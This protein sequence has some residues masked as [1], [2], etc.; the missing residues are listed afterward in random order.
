MKTVLM[1]LIQVHLQCHLQSSRCPCQT[2]L[3]IFESGADFK[4]PR[5]RRDAELDKVNNITNST[6]IDLIAS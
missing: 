5:I 1:S 2:D 6:A 4:L 3:F